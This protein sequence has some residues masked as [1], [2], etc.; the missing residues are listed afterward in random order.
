[1]KKI[2]AQHGFGLIEV[3]ISTALASLVLFAF[4]QVETISVRLLRTEKDNVEATL[5]AQEGLEAVRSVRDESWTNNIGWRTDISSPSLPYYPVVENGKWKLA[6]SSP[7]LVNGKY[8]RYV[9]FEKVMR[10]GS[11]Q[12]VASGGTDDPGTKKITVRATTTQ[13]AAILT[14]YLTNFQASLT[15]PTE[16]KLIYFEDAPTNADLANFPSNNSGDGDPA[17]SFLTLVTPIKVTKIELLLRRATTL[18]SNMY[19]ELRSSP[20][21]M[22]LATSIIISA[23]TTSATALTWTE[24]RFPDAIPLVALTTYYIRLRSVP[25]STDAG[26]GSVG[27]M[28]WGYRQ[29]ASSPYAGG[30][31][32]RYVGRLSN[33]S[34]SGQVLTQYD[35]G[36]RVFALQ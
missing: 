14:S 6:T 11:D 9:I 15:Q 24:F 29:T 21:G 25:S 3:V 31:A 10:N 1:M 30:E 16:A 18:P 36:F 12:I 19:V 23:S 27:T 35:F 17:Q 34:D 20:T 33:P 13:T 2:T 7:G 5:I 28:H 32:R 4:L 26:S 8:N 22:P